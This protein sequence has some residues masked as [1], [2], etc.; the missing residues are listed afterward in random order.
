[1]E[2]IPITGAFDF[3]ALPRSFYDPSAKVVAQRLLGHYLIRRT[4]EG[5]CGGPIVETEAYVKEDPACHAFVGLTNRNRVMWGN[6]GHAYVY[7]IYGFYFCF[8]TVCRPQGQAEAVLVRAIEAKFGLDFMGQNRPVQHQTQLTSGPGKL[9]V[10]MRIDRSFDGADLCDANSPI[11]IAQNPQLRTFRRALG[12]M[13]TTT[14]IG[15]TQA[16]DWPLRYYLEK[17]PF[18]SKKVKPQARPVTNSSGALPVLPN[19]RKAR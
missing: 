7:L 2:K 16:A 10:A 14:R 8:N 5:F 6:P 3:T 19:G 15:L 1:M 17:S 18:V 9:C 4:P 12:P 11:F 13:V